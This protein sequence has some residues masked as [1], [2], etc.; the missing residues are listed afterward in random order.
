MEHPKE[1]TERLPNTEVMEHLKV[2]MRRLKVD[3]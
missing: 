2:D 3:L 1:G